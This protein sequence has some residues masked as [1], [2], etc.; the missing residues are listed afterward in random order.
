MEMSPVDLRQIDEVTAN[1]YEAVIVA[2]KLARNINSENKIE[3]N[4]LLSTIPS[5]GND[6]EVED[7]Q[8]PAQLKISLDFEAREKPHI[9]AL[10][11]VLED[12]VDYEYKKR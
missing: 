8:N 11:E 5:S 1:I 12:K 10:N 3:Y 2:S 6:D 4:A 9:Q 7:V